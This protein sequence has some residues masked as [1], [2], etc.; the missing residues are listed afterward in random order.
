MEPR[1]AIQLLYHIDRGLTCI[2]NRRFPSSITKRHSKDAIHVQRRI[3]IDP[4]PLHASD[5]GANLIL[6]QALGWSLLGGT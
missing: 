6:K 2:R 5:S 3:G 1:F 4:L